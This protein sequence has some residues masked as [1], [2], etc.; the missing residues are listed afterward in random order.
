MNSLIEKRRSVRK[1]KADAPVS[2]QQ[3]DRLLDAAMHAPSA[4]NSRP[5]EFIAVT[6]RQKLDAIANTHP[7]AQMCRTA[8][9]AIV[10]VALPQ[11]GEPQEGFYPQD[12]A[13][14]TQNILLE[15]VDMGLGACWCGVHP[16]ENRIA[17]MR[18]LFDIPEPKVPFCVIAIG[19]PDQEPSKKGSFEEAKVSYIL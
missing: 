1:F 16:K 5:W 9:A 13:A 18:E 2:R 4:C 19:T 3:L 11:I 7:F 14:A 12:C 10:V 15:A 6:N 8:S 17:E